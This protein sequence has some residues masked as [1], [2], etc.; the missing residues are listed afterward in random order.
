MYNSIKTLLAV[1]IIS[2]LLSACSVKQA[3]TVKS[4]I[5]PATPQANISANQPELNHAYD[6]ILLDKQQKSTTLKN[7]IEQLSTADIIFIGEFHGN[8]ASH[9][10]EMQ[11]L[12]ALYKQNPNLT[13]SM[14]M[15]NRDQ[16]SILNQYLDGE[17][18]EVYLVNEAPAWNNYVASYRPLV[19]FAKQNFI[20]VIAAN[21]SAD[22]VRCIGRQGSSYL[23]KLDSNEKQTIAQQPFAEIPNYKDKYFE[24]LEK[25]RTLSEQ[26]KEQSYLAQ[27]TRDNTMAESIYQAWLNNPKQQIVHINGSF[28]SENHLGTVAAL[29]QLNP[30]LK[31]KV[32]TP[33]Q[34]EDV[35]QWQTEAKDE[36]RQDDFYYLLKPQPEQYVNMAYKQKSRKSLFDKAEQ[37]TCK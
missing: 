24:F 12:A 28:H 17:I 7:T 23:N 6:Y 26:R 35:A 22:I 21:A 19:E 36:N 33:I 2:G 3:Q 32:I 4:E 16:Q 30:Q 37:A 34:I 13:L 8:H 29:Q 9:L 18:G 15:F 5:A 1:G 25:L 10:L 14:E 11:I 20:P 27:I 31:I